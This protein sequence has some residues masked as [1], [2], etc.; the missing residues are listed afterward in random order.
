MGPNEN[1]VLV[2]SRY[3]TSGRTI[4][5]YLKDGEKV[6]ESYMGISIEAAL[7]RFRAAHGLKGQRIPKA[8]YCHNG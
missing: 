7:R 8:V 6:K 3:E 1:G 5:T 4:V 2:V